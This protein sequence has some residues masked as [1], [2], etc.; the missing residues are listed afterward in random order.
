VQHTEGVWYAREGKCGGCAAE[1]RALTWG[2]GAQRRWPEANLPGAIRAEVSRRHSSRRNEPEWNEH[3]KV[4][5]GLTSTKGRTEWGY[6]NRVPDA[7]ADN[8]GRRG[9]H[10]SRHDGRHMDAQERTSVRS[11]RGARPVSDRNGPVRTRT[12]GGVGPAAGSLIQSR[13]PDCSALSFL[14]AS[15]IGNIKKRPFSV[16]RR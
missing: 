7:P 10:E 11:S 12:Q 13:G 5:G 1:Q 15:P 16:D 3:V 8:A 2:T 4:A 6:P 9:M 14:C